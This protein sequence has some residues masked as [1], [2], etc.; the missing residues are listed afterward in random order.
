VASLSRAT[1]ESVV[2]SA[3]VR[4]KLLYTQSHLAFSAYDCSEL[5]LVRVEGCAQLDTID[6]RNCPPG[7]CVQLDSQQR[8][9]LRR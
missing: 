6:V 2:E 9:L 5:E 1:S 3:T 7:F 4:E 8:R